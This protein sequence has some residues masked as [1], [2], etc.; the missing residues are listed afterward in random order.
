MSR[1]AVLKL[2]PTL[3]ARLFDIRSQAII[4]NT[5]PA[6]RYGRDQMYCS[7]NNED[8]IRKIEMNR[9]TNWSRRCRVSIS[10]SAA[11]T[12]SNAEPGPTPLTD[13]YEMRTPIKQPNDNTMRSQA[14]GN[15]QRRISTCQ[16]HAEQ[17]RKAAVTHSGK[18][19]MCGITEKASAEIVHGKLDSNEPSVPERLLILWR[20]WNS[21]RSA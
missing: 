21:S 16:R 11:I 17:Q 20:L 13:S 5:T 8:M 14:G 1:V 15:R 10:L 6:I 19:C 12:A 7:R 3:T 2:T 18:Y 9:R 4:V